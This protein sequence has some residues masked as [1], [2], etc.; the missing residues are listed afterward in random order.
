[1]N[2]IRPGNTSA[3]LKTL[4]NES[5]IEKF[6]LLIL[7]VLLSGLIIP[8]VTSEIQRRK[9]RND[10]LIQAQTKLL[11]DVTRTIMTY[12]TL[13]LDISWYQTPD[14]YNREMH[15]KAFNRYSDRATELLTD[16]RVES[17][18]ARY[19]SSILISNRLD[20]LQQEMFRLQ[21]SP[22]NILYREDSSVVKWQ[23]L[24]SINGKMASDARRL[25][26]DLAIE[27]KLTNDNIK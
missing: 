7:T 4:S 10:I 23:K 3:V 26:Y 13:L 15:R 8:Y 1:M 12:E 21:D 24:H 17:L 20:S 27:M 19:L 25:I 9:T 14:G 5:F 22:M 16:W 11:D 18:K 2:T 6:I